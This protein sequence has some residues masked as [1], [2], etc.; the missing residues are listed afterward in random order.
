SGIA[1]EVVRGGRWIENVTWRR[2][3]P[4]TSARIDVSRAI[5]FVARGRLRLPQ[6]IEAHATSRK[7]FP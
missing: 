4:Q 3:V 2:S 1:H 5:A 6:E 7:R